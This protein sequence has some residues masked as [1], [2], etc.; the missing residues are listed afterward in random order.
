MPQLVEVPDDLA[1]EI[2]HE[3]PNPWPWVS[4]Q[5]AETWAETPYTYAGDVVLLPFAG[6]MRPA[7]RPSVEAAYGPLTPEP[8]CPVCGTV[9]F[10]ENGVCGM[11]NVST[12][13]PHG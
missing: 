3:N 9:L 1:T 12:S 13:H 8:H 5:D 6:D 2:G 4:T 7:T 10:W 11:R